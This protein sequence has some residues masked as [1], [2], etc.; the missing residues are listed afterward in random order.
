MTEATEHNW[1]V[2][3]ETIILRAVEDY[4]RAQTRNRLRPHQAE[5]LRL[6]RS[7]EQ[8]FCSEW[9]EVLCSLNGKR[10]LSDLKKEMEDMV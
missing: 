4:R 3:A 7:I 10:L 9:F 5:T 6:I 8:F 2:L 1:Q